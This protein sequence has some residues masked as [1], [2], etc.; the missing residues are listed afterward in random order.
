MTADIRG[1]LARADERHARRVGYDEPLTA[2]HLDALTN[3]VQPL[4]DPNSAPTEHDATI[5]QQH[6]E[7]TALK[8]E[9]DQL[10]EELKAARLDVERR[11]N[12]A[13]KATETVAKTMRE[14][15]DELRIDLAAAKA[16]VP[17]HQHTYEWP[18][19]DEPPLPCECGHPF[20]RTALAEQLADGEP[21]EPEVEPFGDLL[22]RIR[23]ELATW[24][25]QA[26]KALQ[27]L[28]TVAI[29]RCTAEEVIRGA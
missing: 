11:I 24:E 17:Q 26:P 6:G 29:E 22:G 4:V 25:P 5:A 12:T 20:P 23:A 1:A 28:H 16:A 2:A 19:P 7:I 10:A 13:V 15:V 14:K 8:L 18:T 3:A 9:R 21:V 27:S